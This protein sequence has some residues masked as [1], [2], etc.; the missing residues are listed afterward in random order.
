VS[1]RQFREVSL[2]KLTTQLEALRA[3]RAAAPVTRATEIGAE[4][5][6]LLKARGMGSDSIRVGSDAPDFS[7]PNQNGKIVH[8][9]ELLKDGPV[10]LSFYRG[11]WCPFC[12]LQLR[13]LQDALPRILELGATLVAV[14]PEL[15]D[16][17]LTL[18]ERHSLTFSVLSDLGNTVAKQYGLV[19]RLGDE[20]VQAL[21]ERGQ[22]LTAINGEEGANELPIPAT[23]VINKAG[24]VEVT[25]VDSDHT[26]RVDPDHII[27]YLESL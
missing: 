5:I 2:G 10:V 17:S 23:F 16:G 3:E 19:F 24:V 15:P 22:D 26:Y 1:L 18:T 25:C 7:L 12:N 4:A 6:R 21:K 14:S 11:S 9:R 13:A 8:L 27:Q 20:H